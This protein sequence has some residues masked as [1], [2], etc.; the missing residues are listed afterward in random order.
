MLFSPC[1]GPFCKKLLVR[2]QRQKMLMEK[3][4]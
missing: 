1:Y 2:G 4:L 3:H